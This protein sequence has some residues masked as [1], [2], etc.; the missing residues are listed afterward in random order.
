[1]R[2]AWRFAQTLLEIF[3]IMTCLSTY[4]LALATTIRWASAA[5]VPDVPE[6]VF[7]DAQ[8]LEHPAVRK[9][10]DE[11]QLILQKPYDENLTRDGLSFVIVRF[12]FTVC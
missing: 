9:A 11:V 7:T 2:E 8:V 4:F 1:V 10:F 5:C 6:K 3:A 12:V